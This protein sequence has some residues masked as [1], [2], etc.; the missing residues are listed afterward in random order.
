MFRVLSYTCV[1]RIYIILT[2]TV[3]ASIQTS[4]LTTDRNVNLKSEFTEI[5]AVNL[6]VELR[7]S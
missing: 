4:N 1:V 7:K 6:D 5:L 3:H 2:K